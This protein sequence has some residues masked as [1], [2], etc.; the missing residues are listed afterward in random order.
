VDHDGRQACVRHSILK[1]RADRNVRVNPPKRF[2]SSAH[3]TVSFIMSSLRGLFLFISFSSVC[4]SHVIR[5]RQSEGS[6]TINPYPSFA[7]SLCGDPCVI[8]FTSTRLTIRTT[9]PPQTITQDGQLQVVSFDEVSTEFDLAATAIT[10]SNADPSG[11]PSITPRLFT[12]GTLHAE[13]PIPTSSLPGK[14]IIPRAPSIPD[15]ST[16]SVDEILTFYPPVRVSSPSGPPPPVPAK[17]ICPHY[18]FRRNIPLV[19][20]DIVGCGSTMKGQLTARLRDARA[21]LKD[22]YTNLKA[23][24]ESY[25]VNPSLSIRTLTFWAKATLCSSP[26]AISTHTSSGFLK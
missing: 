9:P 7:A 10:I 13:A 14:D 6:T 24:Y 4:F 23:D 20:H 12:V 21:T 26:R 11:T 17:D 19:G 1:Y 15:F 25:V 3:D 2:E 22:V 16:L 5:K 18:A 8:Q